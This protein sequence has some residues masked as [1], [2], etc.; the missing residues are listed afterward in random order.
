MPYNERSSLVNSSKFLNLGTPDSPPA[1]YT[2]FLN[3][4]FKLE[5]AFANDFYISFFVSIA[6]FFAQSSSSLN[7]K[8]SVTL[9]YPR[10][11]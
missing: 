5:Q 9:A 8:I 3:F 7:E 10:P 11:D 2:T 1:C 6:F 4:A